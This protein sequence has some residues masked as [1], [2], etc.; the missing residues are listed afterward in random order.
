MLPA[1]QVQLRPK[2]T[3][4]GGQS[5][6]ISHV[7]EQLSVSVLYSLLFQSIY[8]RL[9]GIWT[10][11]LPRLTINDVQT[12]RQMSKKTSTLGMPED[13]KQGLLR[14]SIGKV[15]ARTAVP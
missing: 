15:L 13:K 7:G 8:R 10:G 9:L 14:P 11:V 5:I 6:P 1:R 4:K 2:L 12:A 3:P